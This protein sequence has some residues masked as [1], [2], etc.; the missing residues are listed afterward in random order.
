MSDLK[1][2]PKL[3]FVLILDKRGRHLNDFDILL[4]PVI[5][6]MSRDQRAHD[7][8]ALLAAQEMALLLKQ[9]LLVLFSLSTHFLF[10]QSSHLEHSLQGIAETQ[11]ELQ[12]SNIPLG[13]LHG[14]PSLGLLQFCRKINPGLVICDFDPLTEHISRMTSFLAQSK[15]ATFE[16]DAHNIVPCWV[17]SPKKEFSA[18]TIRPKIHKYLPDFL[19]PFP[20]VEP[21]PYTLNP[22]AMPTPPPLSSHSLFARHVPGAKAGLEKL[23]EFLSS[24]ICKY[25]QSRND[26]TR[27]GTSD[28]SPYLH[29]GHLSAQRVALEV[30]TT[31]GPEG[32][33]EMFLE[34]LIVRRELA[35]NFCFYETHYDR[36][37]GAPDWGRATLEAHRH[38]PRPYIYD[39]ASFA[40]AQTHDPLWNAAQKQMVIDGKMHNYLRMYWAKKILE[41]TENPET[42]FEIAVKL[43]DTFELD[44]KD[45]NGYAGISWAIAGTHDR[46]WA[47]RQIFGKVRYMN[48]SGCKRKFD[49]QAYVNKWNGS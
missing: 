6:W 37:E 15:W 39:Y 36:L 35:D 1:A 47:E 12:K 11:M 44:G 21:H 27:N 24:G 42:A 19:E 18:Y 34:E 31:P 22:P 13:L 40:S 29:F 30:N 10:S 41:W 26:A 45:P 46:A 25:E 38:D 16:V 23:N 2:R 8:W 43:N 17:T 9:P 7:N 4:G 3:N 28:L 5:Y 20:Q 33:K 48:E 32:S 14:D 49:I